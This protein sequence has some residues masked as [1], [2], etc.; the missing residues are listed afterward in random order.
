[1][2]TEEIIL[3]RKLIK[4]YIYNILYQVVTVLAPLITIPYIT[5]VLG[6]TML[7]VN[8]FTASFVQWFVIFGIMGINNYG[9]KTIGTVRDDRKKLSET[10]FGIFLMQMTNLAVVLIIYLL[11]I[12]LGSRPYKLIYFI[13]GLTIVSTMFDISWFYLGIEDFKINSIRNIL[14]KIIGIL[15][16]YLFVKST[17]DLPVFVLIN[18]SVAVFG[19]LIMFLQLPRYIDRV[20]V[21]LKQAYQ[22]HF[23]DNL[24]LFIPQIATSVYNILDQ[25]LVGMLAIDWEEQSAYYQQAI[26]FVRMFLYFITSIGSVLMPRIANVYSKGEDVSGYLNTTMRLALYLAIPI[27]FGTASVAPSL[28]PWFLDSSFSIV[29]TLIMVA[30]PIILLVSLSN[31]YGIQYLLPTGRMKEYSTSVVIGALVNLF[32]NILLIPRMGALG[33]CIAIVL[34]ES[35]VTLTQMIFIRN[36]LQFDISARTVILYFADGI[37]MA[38]IVMLIGRWMGP[39]LLTNLVQVGCGALFYLGLLTVF[40]EEFHMNMIQKAVEILKK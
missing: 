23:K 36:K 19:Q 2:E 39:R 40:K 32:S 16:I 13:Q 24:V 26:R 33:A 28:I 25:T 12:S 35:S 9:I 31:V 22:D 8:A 20:K 38:G 30:C 14:I 27:M 5:R 7:G 29:S 4:N 18:G 17:D 34:A 6:D 10:F 37:C 21:S 15:L 1:M 11:Y 3:D